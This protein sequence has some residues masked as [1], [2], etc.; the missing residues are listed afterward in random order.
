MIDRQVEL[1]INQLRELFRERS[2]ENFNRIK[3]MKKR[4]YRLDQNDTLTVVINQ[5]CRLGC[6]SCFRTPMAGRL[7]D[8]AL[9]RRLA[10]YASRHFHSLSITGGEPTEVMDLI[11]AA[12]RKHPDL[13]MNVTTSGER[14]DDALI[15]CLHSS[16]NIFP[17]LSLNGIG[18]SHD[19]SRH[20]GSFEII[21]RSLDNLRKRQIPYGVLTVIN[22]ANVALLLSDELVNFFDEIGACTLEFLQYYPIGT[23]DHARSGLALSSRETD[24]SLRYREML[25]R[26]N[27]YGFLY[28][29]SQPQKRRCQRALQVFCG[30]E[31]SYCPFSAWGF[32]RIE[33]DDTDDQI[34]SKLDS[35]L[36][37]WTGLTTASPAYC[38]LQSNTKGYIDFF[39]GFGH[40]L[41]EPTGILD[42][43]SDTHQAYCLAA[44]NSQVL[45]PEIPP[46]G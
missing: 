30:G 46:Q 40:R 36:E 24:E 6:S 17:V 15:D 33:F 5:G 12:A 11:V 19:A 10:D 31:V 37:S 41:A 35:H 38:P 22:A 27:T 20:P 21:M 39:S 29:S 9:F 7:M 44:R 26:R 45:N 34:K 43:Q 13:R 16:P 2:I 14:F 8:A 1:Q 18:E 4:H 3:S 42:E 23:R 32:D 25:E 28:R